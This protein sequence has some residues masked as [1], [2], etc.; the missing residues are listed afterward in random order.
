MPAG[1]IRETERNA[2]KT[3]SAP[4]LM[5]TAWVGAASIERTGP[6]KACVRFQCCTRG[7]CCES[8]RWQGRLRQGCKLVWR[9]SAARVAG[10]ARGVQQLGGPG[11]RR[12]ALH[13]D[14]STIMALRPMPAATGRAL[15]PCECLFVQ[16]TQRELAKSSS[17]ADPRWRRRT[18]GSPPPKSLPSLF[19]ENVRSKDW[20]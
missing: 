8:Q 17:R 5:A 14:S 13:V 9:L 12:R 15:R 20:R 2:R 19:R 11:G 18:G 10:C 16:G 1:D 3:S 7:Q 4:A 6:R